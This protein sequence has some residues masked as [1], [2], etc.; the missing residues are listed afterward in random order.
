M[1]DLFGAMIKDSMQSF[2]SLQ[3]YVDRNL[4]CV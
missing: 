3:D 4:M 1:M 2:W